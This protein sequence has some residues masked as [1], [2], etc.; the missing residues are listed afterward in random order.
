MNPLE[1]WLYI[2]LALM[3]LSVPFVLAERTMDR[4]FRVFMVGTCSFAG[5]ALVVGLMLTIAWATL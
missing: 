1:A 2:S 3:L 4:A 5:W